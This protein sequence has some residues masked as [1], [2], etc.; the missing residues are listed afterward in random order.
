MPTTIDHKARIDAPE[1]GDSGEYGRYLAQISGCTDCH[2][3]DLAGHT[4]PPGAPFA[5]AI[6]SD[7]LD[8]WRLDDLSSAV[9]DGVGS[10][11]RTL[12]PYM[13]YR[14]YSGMTDE[15]IQALWSYLKYTGATTKP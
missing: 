15:E 14:T 12:D 10:D 8:G 13:P 4:G 3:A 1:P 6:H 5:P 2:G 7:A 9:R 11:G